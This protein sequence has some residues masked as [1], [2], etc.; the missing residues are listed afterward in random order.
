MKRKKRGAHDP[1]VLGG[2]TQ[3]RPP[4]SHDDHLARNV[5][6]EWLKGISDPKIVAANGAYVASV[7]VPP[8]SFAWP[9]T[10]AISQP[11]EILRPGSLQ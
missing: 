1:R 3:R 8:D 7:G 4:R 6:T 11:A 5:A 10:F 9:V 2:Q